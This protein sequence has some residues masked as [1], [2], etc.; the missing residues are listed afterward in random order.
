MEDLGGLGS[1]MPV[2]DLDGNEDAI[3]AEFEQRGIS[4]QD[5]D[6]RSLAPPRKWGRTS[7][8]KDLGDFRLQVSW[9][10]GYE[11]ARYYYDTGRSAT[12]I[13]ILMGLDQLHRT[14]EARYRKVYRL[15]GI[16]GFRRGT[17]RMG[18]L[19]FDPATGELPTNRVPRQRGRRS[20]EE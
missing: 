8:P 15:L 7:V 5:F 17:P 2:R 18:R 13:I 20:E 3:Y 10:F 1:A 14:P 6:E 9:L 19:E 12:E 16:N 11:V 4:R